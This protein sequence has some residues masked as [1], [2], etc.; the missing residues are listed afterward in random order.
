MASISD[1]FSHGT[2]NIFDDE[3]PGNSQNI[4]ERILNRGFDLVDSIIRAKYGVK[5]TIPSQSGSTT[6]INAG[7]QLLRNQPTTGAGAGI[8]L[9][10]VAVVLIFLFMRR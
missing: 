10:I 8:A 9:L 3:A 2:P 4:G 6:Q 7:N 5:G 1:I